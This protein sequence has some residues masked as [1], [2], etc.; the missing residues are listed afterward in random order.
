SNFMSAVA[1]RRGNLQLTVANLD[2]QLFPYGIMYQI[3]R[4]IK[5]RLFLESMKMY[6]SKLFW[7]RLELVH[8]IPPKSIM[9]C[10]I[11]SMS[12][13]HGRTSPPR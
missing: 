12:A 13:E 9:A 1:G 8:F 10:P 7:T 6:L 5:E 2:I 4:G 11:T 3:L